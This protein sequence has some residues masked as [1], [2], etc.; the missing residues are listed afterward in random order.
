MIEDEE[1]EEEDELEVE[2]PPTEEEEIENIEE[3]LKGRKVKCTC[4]DDPDWC[5]VHNVW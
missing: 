3:E 1:I 5:E 2:L 4:D